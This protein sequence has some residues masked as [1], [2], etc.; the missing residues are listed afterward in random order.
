MTKASTSTEKVSK[1]NDLQKMIEN[2]HFDIAEVDKRRPW[3]AFFRLKNSEAERFI[4]M[5][6]SDIKTQFKT[7]ENLSPKYLLVEPGQQLSWQYHLRRAEHWRVLR[8]TVGV[9]LSDS[10]TQPN[11]TV[12]LNKGG[13]IQFSAEK[14]HRLIGLDEWGVVVEIWEHI[15][16]KASDEADIVRVEDS[17][18]R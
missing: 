5:Y 11:E 16:N 18:G 7:F 13:L 8:G 12:K 6:F 1:I 4:D 14:R 2:K 3:G 10:D 15:S 17:Y 9:K